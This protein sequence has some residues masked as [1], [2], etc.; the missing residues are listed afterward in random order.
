[1]SDTFKALLLE[2]RDGAT[3]AE[4][5]E[6][7]DADLPDGDVLVDVA[8]SDLNYKDGLAITGRGKVVRS[9]PMVPGIDF[10]GTVAESRHPDY[11]PGDQVVLTGWGVG[12]RHWGGLAGRAVE[13]QPQLV[14]LALERLLARRHL[15]Q[16]DAEREQVAALIEILASRLFG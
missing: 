12:E 14:R 2:Q 16:H 6:L 5:R 15:V 3:H 10:A 7:R 11:R 9:F 8:F 4:I 13:R 1:M